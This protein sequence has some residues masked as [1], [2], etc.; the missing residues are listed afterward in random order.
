MNHPV[1][2]NC[3]PGSIWMLNYLNSEATIKFVHQHASDVFVNIFKII[4]F[5]PYNCGVITNRNVD[6]VNPHHLNHNSL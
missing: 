1:S 3:Q 2:L 6:T 5:K 4:I